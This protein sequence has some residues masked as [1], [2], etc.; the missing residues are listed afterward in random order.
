M[1]AF[2]QLNPQLQL[3]SGESSSAVKGRLLTW[4]SDRLLVWSRPR[5]GEWLVSE[6]D[7]NFNFWHSFWCPFDSELQSSHGSSIVLFHSIF[8][9]SNICLSSSVPHDCGC[10]TS[11]KRR[12]DLRWRDQEVWIWPGCCLGFVVCRTSKLSQ[13]PEDQLMGWI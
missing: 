11:E 6:R 12:V 4:L 2:R 3:H 9:R 13:Q 8:L 10:K 5:G 1:C 7:L